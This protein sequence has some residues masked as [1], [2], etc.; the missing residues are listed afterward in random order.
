MYARTHQR[1][2]LVYLF[3]NGVSNKST[4]KT[5]GANLLI[6]QRL[7]CA[8]MAC[9]PVTETEFL[10]HGVWGGV[11][12]PPLRCADGSDAPYRNTRF[13]GKYEDG[14]VGEDEWR[15][16]QSV[17]SALDG[18]AAAAEALVLP[19]HKCAPVAPAEHQPAIFRHTDLSMLNTRR[20]DE[21]VQIS[22]SAQLIGPRG[23]PSL[24][25]LT[26]EGAARMPSALVL[27]SKLLHIAK[28]H[29]LLHSDVRPG[30]I[31]IDIPAPGPRGSAGGSA[32][33]DI[34]ARVIDT[35]SW[36]PLAA[37]ASEPRMALLGVTTYTGWLG[38][39]ISALRNFPME[40]PA[41]FDEHLL[42]AEVEAP[43]AAF[44]RAQADLRAALDAAGSKYYYS[45][46]LGAETLVNEF[47]WQAMLAVERYRVPGD[48]AHGGVW[49]LLR[50]PNSAAPSWQARMAALEAAVHDELHPERPQELRRQT[51]R[52]ADGWDA[53][54]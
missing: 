23:G 9:A 37:Y 34:L 33:G 46:P 2:F 43:L 40:P 6:K 35:A 30:N 18:D 5:L 25:A 10:G 52:A 41:K 3:C 42:A 27:R 38:R 48:D 26:A 36:R 45:T 53:A 28:T 7:V 20:E 1:R 39:R 54:L 12:S 24:L 21:G 13:V 19:V 44:I 15:T 16:V 49:T 51:V 31:V 11:F 50:S 29:G 47:M 14:D 17:R 8:N 22:T 32:G 4:H